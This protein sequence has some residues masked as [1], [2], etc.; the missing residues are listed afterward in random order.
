M[1]KEEKFMVL[2]AVYKSKLSQ[3]VNLMVLNKKI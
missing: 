1:Q 2:T 3:K